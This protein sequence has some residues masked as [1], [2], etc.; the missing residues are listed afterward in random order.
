MLIQEGQIIIL[1]QL[2]DPRRHCG[3]IKPHVPRCFLVSAHILI[4]LSLG[5]VQLF[6]EPKLPLSIQL[7]LTKLLGNHKLPKNLSF[8]ELLHDTPELNKTP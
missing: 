4:C 5:N 7:P 3:P 1:G 2:F 6:R 8:P